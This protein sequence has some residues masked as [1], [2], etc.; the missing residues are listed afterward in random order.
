MKKYSFQLKILD[1]DKVSK[2][3]IV[4]LEDDEKPT[5]YNIISKRL[6]EYFQEHAKKLGFKNEIDIARN[7]FAAT[8]ET[9]EQ[10]T[11]YSVEEIKEE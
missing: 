1:M 11:Y 2:P 5:P 9:I 8:N 6:S 10:L 4:E 3:Q 7:V